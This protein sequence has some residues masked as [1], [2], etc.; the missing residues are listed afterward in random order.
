MVRNDAL[1][2]VEVD[3]RTFT[4][5]IDGVAPPVEAASSVPLSRRYLLR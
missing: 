1:P 3:P 2:E 5:R 4:V